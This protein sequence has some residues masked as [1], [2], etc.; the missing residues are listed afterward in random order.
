MLGR[1][2]VGLVL[3]LL[4]HTAAFAQNIGDYRTISSN[5]EF[6]LASGWQVYTGTTWVNNTAALDATKTFYVRHPRVV[7]ADDN[8]M[9]ARVILTRENNVSG[10]LT[11]G[12]KFG[13]QLLEIDGVNTEVQ[14]NSLTAVLNEVQVRNYGLLRTTVATSL[15]KL[16]AGSGGVI[17]VT[18]TS[19]N[20]ADLVGPITI[21]DGGELS[22]EAPSARA[23]AVTVKANGLLS[24]RRNAT[25]RNVLVENGGSLKRIKTGTTANT[26]TIGNTAANPD[27]QLNGIYEDAPDVTALVVGANANMAVGATGRYLHKSNG[28]DVPTASWDPASTLEILG[29]T[30][31]ASFGNN[32]QTFGNVT[33]NTPSY[34]DR[35]ATLNSSGL[36]QIA[37]KLNVI[38]TGLGKLDLL[39]TAV[40]STVEFQV[41]SYEQSGGQ[42]FI[43]QSG[44]AV[45]K[46]KVLGNFLLNNSTFTMH[47]TAAVPRSVLTIEGNTTLEGQANLLV[48]TIG[49]TPIRGELHLHGD[50]SLGANTMISETG[51]NGNSAI[52]AQV[53]FDGGRQQNF[54]NASNGGMLFNRVHVTVVSGT[55]LNMGR[56]ELRNDNAGKSNFTLQSG[57][58]LIMGHAEGIRVTGQN[59]AIRTRGTRSFSPGATYTYA[60]ALGDMV[61]G[62]GLPVTLNSDGGLVINNA[63]GNVTLSQTTYINGLLQ[64][65]QGLLRTGI[66]NATLRLE[67]TGSWSGASDQSYVS[68]PLQRVTNLANQYY[69]FPI[70]DE[71]GLQLAGVRP[72]NTTTT[73]FEMDTRRTSAPS[74]TSFAANSGLVKVSSQQYWNLR[75]V[76]GTANAYVRLYYTV[77]YS[78]ISETAEA[79]KELRVAGFDGSFWQ[80]YGQEGLPNTLE[81]YLNS[82]AALPITGNFMPVTFGSGVVRTPLPIELISFKAKLL[83]NQNVQLTWQTA[84]ERDCKQFE[85]QVSTDGR[86]FKGIGTYQARGAATSIA[87][88]AHTDK[89]AFLGTET[90]RYY[91]LEQVDNDGSVYYFPVVTVNGSARSVQ[92]TAWPVPATDQLTVSFRAVQ[93]RTAIRILDAAGRVCTEQMATTETN[94]TTAVPLSVASLQRGIYLVQITSANGLEQFR[95]VK[96]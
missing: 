21:N 52:N 69:T 78:G 31:A 12:G 81:H 6:S 51:S 54:S 23:T 91:R 59:G 7:T 73:I 18:G 42:V 55:T 68:G 67:A 61:T 11:L 17:K 25:L 30:D 49:N 29:M 83:P 95:F 74:P 37:G 15:S 63:T 4:G 75:R 84:Q 27:L 89:T 24:I 70:G 5:L 22:M 85:V 65:Q 8:A 80:S 19:A 86:T 41:G 62:D 71:G 39:N 46:V 47:N 1:W 9:Y 34:T 20:A 40:G 50:L 44:T 77:P 10:T 36:M 38:S 64:L 48:T 43:S 2:L 76:S 14:V 57:A 53:Y 66:S 35:V 72:E 94:T 3:I 32:G 16:S 28:G 79:Q 93:P 92:L 45:Q 56:A 26:L 90:T 96:E 33:W 60:G 82:G 87:S 88:Y 58:G 13:A